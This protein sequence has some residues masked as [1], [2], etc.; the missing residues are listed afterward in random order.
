M[1]RCVS[2]KIP[3]EV[4]GD[5]VDIYSAGLQAEASC[6]HASALAQGRA[7]AEVESEQR[8]QGRQLWA[9]AGVTYL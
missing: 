1:L 6:G 2:P 7:H 3:F 5:Q 8:M 9:Q 4:A